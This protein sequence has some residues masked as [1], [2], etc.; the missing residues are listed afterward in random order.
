MPTRRLL[1]SL[2]L[3]AGLAACAGTEGPEALPPLV[4]GY[5]HLTPLRLNLLEI[6]LP[7]PAAGAVRVAEPAPLR[8]DVEMRRMAEERLVPVGTAGSGRFLISAARFTRER[9]PASGGLTA[10]FAGEPGERIAVEMICRLEVLNA[11]ARRV[12]FVEAQARRS[13]TLA[14]GTAPAARSRAA[15]EL[16]RQAMDE[17]NVEFEYQIRR[18]LREWLVDASQ[19]VTPAPVEREDLPQGAPRG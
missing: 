13:R 18:T 17:L 16:V 6:A 7:D 1:L 4:T 12:A 11:E 15:E 9:L 8:P 3:G 19:P 14:D 5:R 10:M 2:P